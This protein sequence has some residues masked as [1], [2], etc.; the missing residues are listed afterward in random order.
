M[1]P[2]QTNQMSIVQI[3]VALITPNPKQPRKRFDQ[4][5]LEHLTAS[6]KEHGMTLR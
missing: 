1:L 6:V 5:E 3:P 2:T 4:Q